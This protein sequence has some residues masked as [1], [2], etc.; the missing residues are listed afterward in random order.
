ME[1]HFIEETMQTNK[2][3]VWILI[4]SLFYTGNILGQ[5]GFSL[6]TEHE[7]NDNPFHSLTPEN[8]YIS[9]FDLGIENDLGSLSAGYYGSYLNFD[10]IPERNFYWHQ[11]AVW[12]DFEN[13]TIGAYAEQRIGRDIYTYFD[14]TNYKIYFQQ[15]LN[16]DFLYMFFSPS[17][18]LS[19]YPDI[20]IMDNFKGSL[21]YSFN[22][23]FETGTTFIIGGEVNYKKY[24]D[25]TQSGYYTYT[26]ETN[27]VITESYTDNNLSSLTQLVSFIRAAQSITPT[28]GIAA[29]LTNRNIIER[30]GSSVK[31]L[32]LYYGDESEM[33]DDPVNYSGNNLAFEITQILFDDMTIKAGYYFNKKFYP[34]QGIYD[35]EYYYSTDLMRS[36]TQNVFNFSITKNITLGFLSDA[37]CAV[38][39]NYKFIKN[40]SN[41]YLF[42]YESNSLNFNFGIEF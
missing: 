23:G 19:K 8:T 11:L 38:G 20:A 32:N 37:G 29:Q 42:N 13:A 1:S 3:G 18:S 14:Y 33:F 7:Y 2:L 10:I 36:D 22:K 5:W 34:S 27:Q 41:S 4:L 40:S 9:S 16:L 24:L 31:D 12:K 28:T 25:P 30:M 35:A 15:Q 6:S 21:A 39:I 26:D 17:I